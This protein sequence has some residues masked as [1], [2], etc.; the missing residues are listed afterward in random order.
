[1]A[2]NF[3]SSFIPSIPKDPTSKEVFKKKNTS[4]LGILAMILF[5]ISLLMAIGIYAYK[6]IL[7]N[8]IITLQAKMADAE[9]SIDKETINDMAKFS[10]KLGIVRS[11]VIKHQ[12]VSN[13]LDVLAKDT[14]SSVYFT[15]FDY[16]ALSPNELSVTMQ[17]RASNYASLALQ[18]SVFSKN[19]NF[20]SVDFSNLDL[21]EGGLVSFNLTI[22]VDPQIAVFN[23]VPEKEINETTT[24]SSTAD[25]DD[26]SSELDALENMDLGI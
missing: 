13:F 18:D 16:D 19:K 12:V 26:V 23:A 8:D 20:R 2:S 7:R 24:A 17:G 1:M 5:I 4:I 22:S 25:I 3:Q 6:S 9:G 10:G 11:I 21:T 14:V 15:S